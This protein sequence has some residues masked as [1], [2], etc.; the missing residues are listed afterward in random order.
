MSKKKKLFR[1]LKWI[2]ILTATPVVLVGIMLGLAAI[3]AFGPLPNFKELENPSINLASEMY[4][5]DGKMLGKF[6]VENRTNVKYEDINPVVIDA[7]ISTE[8]KRF[9]KHSGIDAEAIGR[10]IKGV[11]TFNLEGGGSTITQQLA[12]LLFSD[13][14]KSRTERILQKFQ[15]WVIALRLEKSYTKKE[16]LTMYL[17]KADFGH[18]SFGITSASKIYFDKKPAQLNA[19]EASILVGMLKAPTRYS[20]I[21]YPENSY[22]RRNTVLELMQRNGKLSKE[23][24]EKWKKEPLIGDKE[25]L[26]DRIDKNTYGH[27][28]LAPYFLEEMKKDLDLWCKSNK[29]PNGDNWNFYKDGLRIY[30]T[31]DSRMQLYA[32]QA[33]NQH[34]PELQALFFKRKKGKKNAPFDTRMK[35]EDV[36][37]NIQQAIKNSPRYKEM[38]DLGK[39]ES[40]ILEAFD[41][42]TEMRVFSWKGDIDTVMSPRDSIVYYKYFLQTGLMAMDPHTGFVKAWVGGINFRHFKY[43]HVRAGTLSKDKKYIIPGG[44]RQVGSTFKPFVYLMAM[45]AKR[46]PCELVPNVQVCIEQYGQPDW[47][48]KNSGDYGDGKMITLQNALA[49]SVNYISALLMKQ[50]GPDAIIRYCQKMG[51]ERDIPSTPSIC[52]GTPDVS[53]FEMVGAYCTFFNKGKYIQPVYILRIEDKSGNVLADF[54]QNSVKRQVFSEET[55]YLMIHLMK[56]VVNMGTAGWLRKKYKFKEPVAGKT[57]T[58]QNNSDGWFMGGTPDLVAGVWTGAEDRQVRFASIADGQGATLALPIWGIFMRKVYDDKTITLNRGDFEK[59]RTELNVEMNCSE[60]QQE[61]YRDHIFDNE[62]FDDL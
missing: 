28:D 55:A 30:T 32:E 26:M 46:S 22:N 60:Y 4:S 34:M 19:S 12:K 40:E 57:G 61:E 21:K 14:P 59:P 45:E 20:P 3:G 56:G 23:E 49:N 33:V 6:Y 48:P 5:Y 16:I 10:V 8:D 7:L 24:C 31:I 18:N 36:E 52:L 41:K 11:I 38:K 2:W 15:E 1:F 35:P 54:T 29:K 43:D 51:I 39:S 62:N 44:G 9:Y 17:N 27:G 50:Y 37:K 13:K 42:P 25:K 58:T 53:V 47:C